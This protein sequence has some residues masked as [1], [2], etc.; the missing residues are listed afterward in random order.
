MRLNGGAFNAQ[1]VNGSRRLP[2]YASA[3]AA[4]GFSLEGEGRV[5]VRGQ[6]RAAVL[7]EGAF[8]ASALRPASGHEIRVDL[9]ALGVGARRRVGEGAA[10]PLELH[11]DPLDY[12]VWR[13]G[14]GTA[15][16][17]FES[18]LVPRAYRAPDASSLTNLRAEIVFSA[19]RF[20]LLR[21]EFQTQVRVAPTVYRV[22]TTRRGSSGLGL[23]ASLYYSRTQY[24]NGSAPITLSARADVGVEFLEG[25]GAL[26][27]MLVELTP[28]RRRWAPGAAPVHVFG[29]FAP[30]AVRRLAA[31][32]VF[33]LRTVGELDPAHIAAD[34][35]RYI[36]PSL[37]APVSVHLVDEGLR[38]RLTAGAFRAV[39]VQ[40]SASGALH[41]GRTASA[42]Q[43]GT[44]LLAHIEFISTRPFPDSPAVMRVDAQGSGDVYVRG[45]GE[46]IFSLGVGL[47]GRSARY[48]DG[49]ASVATVAPAVTPLIYRG[50]RGVASPIEAQVVLE[51]SR[52]RVGTGDL[53]LPALL[54]EGGAILYRGASGAWLLGLGARGQGESL[55]YGAGSGAIGVQ[56]QGVGQVA[57]FVEGEGVLTVETGG[58]GAVFVR[59][60]GRAI[61]SLNTSLDLIRTQFLEAEALLEV[62]TLGE[63]FVPLREHLGTALATLGLELERVRWARDL[64]ALV[65]TIDAEGVGQRRAVPR[66]DAEIEVL[67]ASEA[68]INVGGEDTDVQTFV[69]PTELRDFVRAPDERTFL[70]TA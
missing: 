24:G 67:G 11:V 58:D 23:L 69:R 22:G 40:L 25:V 1:V 41:R 29:Q 3:V 17:T 28:N 36:T 45:S 26:H 31:V 49:A 14:F 27:P 6:G 50:M 13:R 20:A 63:W 61:T 33:E 57:R 60:S 68:Y 38:R 70:R 7:L 18:A 39:G 35:V 37:R 66:S 30:S 21:A 19:Q 16:V 54:Q 15:P 64:P 34:G 32:P 51:P 44:S 8:A 5:E 42:T 53:L 12:Q 59:G 65:K 48:I 62:E 2:I 46:A 43:A 9:H 10:A 52:R 56:I 47:Y 4:A 55:V